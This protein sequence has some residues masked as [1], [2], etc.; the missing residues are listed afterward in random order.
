MQCL[1]CH[2]TIETPFCPHCGQSSQVARITGRDIY[3]GIP[4]SIGNFDRGFLHTLVSLLR[5]PV[6]LTR[7]Y[8]SGKRARHQ[9]PL[10]F[11]LIITTLQVILAKLILAVKT[12]FSGGEGSSLLQA[13]PA[14]LQQ[15]ISNSPA[16]IALVLFPFIA[17]GFYAGYRKHGNNIGEH[18]YISLFLFSYI[19][20]VSMLT[21]LLV[22]SFPGLQDYL[23]FLYIPIIYWF[24][25]AFY[26]GKTRGF[27]TSFLRTTASIGL[28][29]G[30]MMAFA[31]AIFLLVM[32]IGRLIS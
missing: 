30:L 20:V 5:N 3:K 27:L 9:K 15:M 6:V 32:Q 13:A 21:N 8:L 17:L 19:Q 31:S 23:G 18:F 22:L 1:N 29:L 12:S 10:Q 26:R 24:Y 7:D 2:N 4:Q 28:T 14:W 16:I 11:F 25:Y